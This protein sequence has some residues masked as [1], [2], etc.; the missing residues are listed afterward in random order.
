MDTGGGSVLALTVLSALAQ[1]VNFSYRVVMARMV[2][3]EV[4]GLY[5]L[6][7]SAYAV[8]QAITT[9]GL[10]S[11]LSNLTAQYL[12]LDDRA[13][14]DQL[15]GTCLGLFFCLMA[16][17]G[18][19]TIVC[20]DAISVHLLGD[21]RTQ[22]G[23]ILLIPCLTLT[24]V[25]NLHKNAF[26]GAGK[27]L[28]PAVAEV[29]EQL[30]RAGAVL[31]L[32][33][34]FLPQYP[35][36][37][38]GLVMYGMI[39]CEVSSAVTLWTLYRQYFGSGT[40]GAPSETGA[41]RTRRIAAIAL[42]VGANA[43]LG[44]FLGAANSALVPRQLVR[45]GM[46][47]SLAVSKLGVVCGM[48]MPMLALPTVY[49]GALNL[50][51]MPKLARCAALGRKSEIRALISQGMEQ[52]CLLTLPC[53]TAM[54][55]LGD[56]L[57]ELLYGR[58]DVGEYLL[59]LAAAMGINCCVSV[60]ATALN[61]IGQQKTVAC[62][63][64]AGGGVQVACTFFLTGLPGVEMGGFVMGSVLSAL[65][66]LL[67]CLGAVVRSTALRLTPGKWLLAPGLSSLLAGLN[68]RLLLHVLKASPLPI[69]WTA[70]TVL[71]FGL[72]Q[73]LIVLW[74]LRPAGRKPI[75][76]SA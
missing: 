45:A 48:T 33:Y 19:V 4:M 63:S 74:L 9:I 42:P 2:G 29:W 25:E 44:N 72:A 40:S 39:L 26:Y 37:A 6:V 10:T 76:E 22:L 17:V 43:L 50:V 53:M 3:A 11:A 59:P 21:A 28:P 27:P 69:P 34:L 64:L 35:E 15:R 68:G 73:Y 14:A 32:L 31:G 47:R 41:Q 60:L 46:E 66:E 52:V 36:R 38:V 70:G 58:N 71:L 65:L 30:V 23:L 5:Q 20:S 24:A 7:M 54:V 62:I 67:L 75:D 8:I 18:A 1:I 16:P 12:A 55:I 61:S 49:L 51:M 57:G 56:D 13:G